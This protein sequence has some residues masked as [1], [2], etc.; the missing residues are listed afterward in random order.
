MKFDGFFFSVNPINSPEDLD[1]SKMYTMYRNLYPNCRKW[2]K[3]LEKNEINEADDIE[4]IRYYRNYVCHSDASEIKTAEFNPRMLDLLG[5]IYL[6]H[7]H[8]Q[9]NFLKTIA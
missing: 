5:V 3:T 2:G 9:L 8:L 4:R 7:E 1:I 6:L